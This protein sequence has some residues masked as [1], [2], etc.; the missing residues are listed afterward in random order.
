MK[1]IKNEKLVVSSFTLCNIHT[2]HVL[3]NRVL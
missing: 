1:E 2:R 3:S